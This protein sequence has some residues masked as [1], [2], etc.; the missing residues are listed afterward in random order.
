MKNYQELLNLKESSKCR[1]KRQSRAVKEA[2]NALI[3]VGFTGIDIAT[4]ISADHTLIEK[5][6]EI[7]LSPKTI[8]ERKRL[9]QKN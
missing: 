3:D 8:R 5:E 1:Y 4:F 2:V 9:S 7:R 6:L